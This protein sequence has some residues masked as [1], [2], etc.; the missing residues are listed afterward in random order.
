MPVT[1]VVEVTHE[2]LGSFEL[3]TRDMSNGGIFVIVDKDHGLIVG[4]QVL[5][6]VKGRLGDGEEP[7]TLKMEIVRTESEGLGLKFID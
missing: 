5:V 3:K 4:H 1:L 6:K 7:P 2:E